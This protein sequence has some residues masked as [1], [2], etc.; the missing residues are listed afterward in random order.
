MKNKYNLMGTSMRLKSI[1]V[2]ILLYAH[3]LKGYT[4][5]NSST[6]Y[7]LDDGINN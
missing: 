7:M 5:T 4:R 3:K 1:T 6:T 2:I